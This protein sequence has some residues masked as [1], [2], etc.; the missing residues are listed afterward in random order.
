MDNAPAIQQQKFWNKVAKLAVKV[1]QLKGKVWISVHGLGV[2]Y[3]HVR[4]STSPKYYF[5][6]ELAS[7]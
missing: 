6:Q 5:D 3:T 1:M 7:G 2:A 4:L